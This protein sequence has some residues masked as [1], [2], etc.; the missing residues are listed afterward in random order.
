MATSTV[1]MDN[2]AVRQKHRMAAGQPVTGQTLPAA[3]ANG[4][5]TPA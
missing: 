3:P 5:K 2:A 1:P 4:P